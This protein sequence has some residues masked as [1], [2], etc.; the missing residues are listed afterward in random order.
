MRV[1]RAATSV[2]AGRLETPDSSDLRESGV[3]SAPCGAWHRHRLH[4]VGEIDPMGV[5]NSA[6]IVSRAAHGGHA[7]GTPGDAAARDAVFIGRAPVPAESFR[8]S[9]CETRSD[10]DRLTIAV[11]AQQGIPH[12]VCHLRRVRQPVH[13]TSRAAS[14]GWRFVTSL[15]G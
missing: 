13:G 1:A 9:L 3:K 8:Q 4:A 2:P 6:P 5:P 10:A 7:R 15:S 11:G 12:P 14:C